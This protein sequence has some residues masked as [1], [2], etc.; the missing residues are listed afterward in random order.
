MQYTSA[1]A[2]KYRELH[3]LAMYVLQSSIAAASEVVCE[4]RWARDAAA[5]AT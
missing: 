4:R 1:I 5:H 3:Q 2:R